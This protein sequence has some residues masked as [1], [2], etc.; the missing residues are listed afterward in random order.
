MFEFHVSYWNEVITL[1]IVRN[2]SNFIY[3]YIS[4]RRLVGCKRFAIKLYG[5]L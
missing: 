3:I 4:I 1:E 2:L 5:F